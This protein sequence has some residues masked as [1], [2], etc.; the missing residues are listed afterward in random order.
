MLLIVII[1]CNFF[2][3]GP[4]GNVKAEAGFWDDVDVKGGIITVLKGL[5]MLWIMN[6]INQNTGT[7]NDDNLITSTIKKG[8]NIDNQDKVIEKSQK[9]SRQSSNQVDVY[10]TQDFNINKKEQELIDLVN[11]ARQKQG[12][13]PLKTNYKLMEIARIKAEDMVKND[14]FKHESPLYGS[15]FEM[16]RAKGIKYFSAG[17]NIAEAK[18]VNK[19]F[20]ELMKSPEHKEN[21]LEKGYDEIGVGVVDGSSYGLMIVQEFIKSR[22]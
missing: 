9:D 4:L 20:Q 2:L 10:P 15:P 19:G 16:M 18:T 14:Y 3:I 21:I 6:L 13:Q 1:M 7:N 8:L 12:L 11:K 22:K 17:E 5:L